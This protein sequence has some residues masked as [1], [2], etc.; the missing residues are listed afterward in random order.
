MKKDYTTIFTFFILLFIALSSVE[1]KA[2]GLENRKSELEQI[3]VYPNPFNSEF[4]LKFSTAQSGLVNVRMFDILGNEIYR[5]AYDLSKPLKEI[6]ITPD[7][8]KL[9]GKSIFIV[10]VNIGE[11]TY[12]YRV[13]KH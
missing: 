10:R 12:S 11:N 3:S 7:S 2:N 5:C 1:A 6:A 13:F 9:A 8:E 4:S